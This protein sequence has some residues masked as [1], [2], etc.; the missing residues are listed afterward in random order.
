MRRLDGDIRLLIRNAHC[1]S[2]YFGQEQ[3]QVNSPTRAEIRIIGIAGIPEIKSGD[4]RGAIISAAIKA[5]SIEISAA[6]RLVV[7]QKIVSKA[8]GKIVRLDD[9]RPS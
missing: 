2:C 1:T 4:N 7:A 6:D 5:Q 8:E 3:F 9:V